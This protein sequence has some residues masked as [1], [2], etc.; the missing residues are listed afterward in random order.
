[1]KKILLL[2]I[3]AA[4]GLVGCSNA[5]DSNTTEAEKR[6]EITVCGWNFGT[7]DAPTLMRKLIENFNETS[8]TSYITMMSPVGDYNEYLNTL[9]S[10]NDLPDI[11]LLESIPEAM[12]SDWL[13]DITSFV[14]ADEEWNDVNTSLQE[15][16]TYDSKVYAV[17]SEQ[18]YIGYVANLDLIENS[19][20]LG[21]DV[22][23]LFTVEN[24]TLDN[25]TSLLDT[26]KILNANGTSTIGLASPADMINWVPASLYPDNYTHFL[27]NG[28]TFDYTSTTTIA[29][30]EKIREIGSTLT[31]DS[32]LSPNTDEIS[33]EDY[34]ISYFGTSDNTTAF[35]EGKIGFIQKGTYETIDGADAPL[36]F[37]YQFIPFPDSTIISA[38]DFMA[39]S[40]STQNADLAFEALKYLTYSV[41]GILDR[42][43][44]VA[45]N[46]DVQLNGLPISTNEA[47]IEPWFD[48]ITLPGLKEV[49]QQVSNAE[50]TV[51]A[52]GNK[53]VPGFMEAR[54]TTEI[55]NFSDI[56]DGETINIGDL[57]WD[58][59]ASDISISTYQTVMTSALESKLNE[60]VLNYFD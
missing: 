53:Y 45:E 24:Y 48:Q 8:E 30:I 22:N 54:F 23:D 57:I 15:A 4:F 25:F 32:I 13:L 17:P 16:V 43:Q 60:Y 34:R 14:E 50:I 7:E 37:N 42:T 46:D 21:S 19:L 6:T 44:I 36:N 26:M 58:V 2:V 3:I 33:D 12:K 55:G 38:L 51:L 27:W 39:I 41:D 9:A 5:A 59:C 28:T 31:F 47:V 40:K 29:S 1:M 52:E 56:R 10:T 11:L 35:N 18:N 20:S 49:F